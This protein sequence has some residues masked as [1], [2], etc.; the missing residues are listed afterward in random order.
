MAYPEGLTEITVTGQVAGV[1][2]GEQAYVTFLQPVWLQGPVPGAFVGSNCQVAHCDTDG[3]FSIVLAAT[4]DPAWAPVDWSYSVSIYRGGA[5]NRGT[6][7]L[8]YDGG[9]VD[10]A[11]AFQPDETPAPGQSYALLPQLTALTDRVEA[12]EE[13]PGGTAPSW[14]S[15]TGKPATFPPSPHSQAISTITGLQDA[16]DALATD[17]EVAALSADVSGLDVRV[18]ALEEAPGGGGTAAT[19]A[20][21]VV[22]SGDV[23]PGVTAAWA[24][25]AGMA[26]SLAAVAGDNVQVDFSGLLNQTATSFFD[27]AVLVG[28]SIVRYASTGTSS[29]TAAGE[30]DPSIYPINGAALRPLHGRMSL[31]VVS[32]DLSG[33]T[34]TFALVYK[35]D[36]AGKVFA[37]TNYPLRWQIRNDHQ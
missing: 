23:T 12:L 33:G 8:P 30:G 19:F 1:A 6:L 34:V 5:I 14:D 37:S 35:G 10:L 36:A 11:D 32:G 20:R 13:A 7:Q 22:S 16:L 15:V 24:P 25:V 28:G 21:G 2:E 17:T 27:I 26:F 3:E 9:S 29:P 18:T 31:A 4:D